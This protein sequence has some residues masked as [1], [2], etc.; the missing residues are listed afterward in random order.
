MLSFIV[1]LAAFTV[2]SLIGSNGYCGNYLLFER[3]SLCL[4]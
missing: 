2:G 4:N 3:M 1:R